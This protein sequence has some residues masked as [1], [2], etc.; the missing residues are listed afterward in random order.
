MGTLMIPAAVAME[1]WDGPG[2]YPS[3]WATVEGIVV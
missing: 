2:V 3:S 1:Y